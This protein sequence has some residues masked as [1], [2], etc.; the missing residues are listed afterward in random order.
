MLTAWPLHS[1]YHRYHL[2]CEIVVT[3]PIHTPH[4]IHDRDHYR[5]D[6]FNQLHSMQIASSYDN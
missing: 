6:F 2:N 1:S 5:Y 3:I 4:I